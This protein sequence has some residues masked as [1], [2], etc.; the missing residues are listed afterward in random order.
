MFTTCLCYYFYF[1]EQAEREVG[2]SALDLFINVTRESR[3][4][5]AEEL[6]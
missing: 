2:L 4:R 6:R 5:V 1:Q 3:E